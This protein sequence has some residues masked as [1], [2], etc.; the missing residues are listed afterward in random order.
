MIAVFLDLVKTSC[1]LLFFEANISK[2]TLIRLTFDFKNNTK[3]IWG[4]PPNFK[5]W[6]D[7]DEDIWTGTSSPRFLGTPFRVNLTLDGFKMPQRGRGGL[8]VRSRPWG[9]RVP[10][11]KPDSTEDPPCVRPVAN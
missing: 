5:Q 6:S 8:E 4:E 2:F 11:S 9:Q 7:D 1:K 3:T 10:G